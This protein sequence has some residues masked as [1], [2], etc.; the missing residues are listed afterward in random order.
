MLKQEQ[1]NAITTYCESKGVEYYDVQLELVDH[2]ADSIE[3]FREA[4]PALS[5]SDTHAN[6]WSYDTVLENYKGRNRAPVDLCFIENKAVVTGYLKNT[7]NKNSE[8]KPGDIINSI[9]GKTVNNIIK[10]KLPYTPASNY[11]TQLRD[12]AKVLLRTND[13]TLKVEYMRNG[14]SHITEIACLPA[15]TVTAYTK[16]AKDSCFI[17]LSPGIG[18]LYPGNFKN[19]YL[20]WLIPQ[21]A[22]TRGLIIDLRCYP[23]DFMVFTVGNYINSVTQ[24]FVK[25]SVGNIQTPGLFTYT[26]P[27]TI[28]G[29]YMNTGSYTGKI[30][31]LINETTLS[32]AEYTTMAFRASANTIVIGSTTA[33]ADGNVSSFFLPGG[34]STAISGLG[35]FYPDGKET[36]RVGII[37]DIVVKPTIKGIAEQRDELVEKAIEII[38]KK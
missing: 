8:L 1:I 13:T 26:M 17:L 21:I 4:D 10:E 19:A 2:I 22:Q 14:Q 20:P 38:N 24:T 32:Q 9:N 37:P 12:I 25:A 31:V 30:V 33:G 28:G 7:S 6:I 35:I 23:S 15:G 29:G 18:Y 36:Q 11:P 16:T 5:F 3:H 34:I 27:L